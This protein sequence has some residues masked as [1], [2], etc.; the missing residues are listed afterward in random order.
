MQTSFGEGSPSLWGLML[1][2]CSVAVALPWRQGL[3][4]GGLQHLLGW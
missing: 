4:W 1:Y 2:Y 3:H